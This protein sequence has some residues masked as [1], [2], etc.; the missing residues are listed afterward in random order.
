MSS[1]YRNLTEEFER[2]LGINNSV[3]D[4]SLD[5]FMLGFS[6]WLTEREKCGR[7]YC[8]FL[9]ETGLIT[10]EILTYEIGKGKE[11]TVT[12]D[13][14]TMLITPYPE[15]P[16][17]SR[18]RII[19]KNFC[20]F[21]NGP[22]VVDFK[23]GNFELST[24][25][26]DEKITCMTQNPYT[27]QNIINWERL[28]NSGNSRIIVGMYGNTFDKDRVEKLNQLRRFR[29][30]LI[31]GTYR[32]EQAIYG[33]TYCYVIASDEKVKRLIKVKTR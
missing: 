32:E 16:K 7:N 11:D 9:E 26:E 30:R 3:N 27:K 28:H 4:L 33:D 14:N 8:N 21:R 22:T 5:T 10:D 6:Q 1:Y 15:V 18:D 20:V 2:T 29:N 12:K 13:L 24:V 19:N 25:R 17:V 31:E 23:L